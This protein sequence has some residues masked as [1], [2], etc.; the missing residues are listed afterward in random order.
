VTQLS[1]KVK[2][3]GGKGLYGIDVSRQLKAIGLTQCK[4]DVI[5]G[6]RQYKPHTEPELGALTKLEAARNKFIHKME[7]R[8]LVLR[9]LARVHEVGMRLQQKKCSGRAEDLRRQVQ[10][11]HTAIGRL[12]DGERALRNEAEF[13]RLSS[14]DLVQAVQSLNAYS[15]KLQ[16]ELLNA[17]VADRPFRHSVSPQNLEILELIEFVRMVTGKS[18]WAELA[19]L[20]NGATGDA[21][22]NRKRLY[23]LYKDREKSGDRTLGSFRRA[24]L[25]VAVK[26][27]RLT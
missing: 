14:L 17:N 15:E 24:R 19:I 26:K 2:N 4:K 25:R 16:I 1:Q 23:Q 13:P 11:V 7:F 12:V 27:L 22:M 8:R 18:H 5:L 20:L 9:H 21:G 3:N 10:N 6:V